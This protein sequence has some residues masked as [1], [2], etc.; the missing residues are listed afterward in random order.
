MH[1][2]GHLSGRIRVAEQQ[3]GLRLLELPA[4]DPL[5]P[6]LSELSSGGVPAAKLRTRGTEVGLPLDGEIKLTECAIEVA[7]CYLDLPESGPDDE[8]VPEAG[9]ED[10]KLAPAR[11]VIE[12]GAREAGIGVIRQGSRTR[13]RGLKRAV[14]LDDVGAKRALVDADRRRLQDLREVLTPERRAVPVRRVREPGVHRDH[15]A[16]G[17]D[18]VGIPAEVFVHLSREQDRGHVIRRE[19]RQSSLFCRVVWAPVE[20]KRSCEIR[21]RQVAARIERHRALQVDHRRLDQRLIRAPAMIVGRRLHL[22]ELHLIHHH[23]RV[24]VDGRL[25]L[26]DRAGLALVRFLDAL[27]VVVVRGVDA[28]PGEERRGQQHQERC[29]QRPAAVSADRCARRHEREASR[30]GG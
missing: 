25:Q 8:I 1:L 22:P 9:R 3:D 20:L 2:T 16:V 13:A 29:A 26:L 21:P 23:A 28:V 24:C 4:D 15:L 5:V 14:R 18:R 7:L 11:R 19:P 10:Q 12:L 17:A 6:R 30:V 27:P